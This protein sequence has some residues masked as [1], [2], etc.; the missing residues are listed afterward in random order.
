LLT[1]PLF[2]DLLCLITKEEYSFGEL[3]DNIW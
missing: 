3:F 2:E 1:Q